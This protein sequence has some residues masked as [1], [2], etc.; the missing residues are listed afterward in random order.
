MT[1]HGHGRLGRLGAIVHR[2]RGRVVL[3]WIAALIAVIALAPLL[4][5]SSEADFQ[6]KGSESARASALL[7]QRFP[8]RSG[9]SVTVVWKASDARSRQVQRRVNGFLQRAER[10]PAVGDAG[11][12][13]VS[14]DGTIATTTLELDR[15]G[16]DVPDATGT[17]LIDLAEQSSGDGLTILLGGNVIRN[18]EGGG[19]PEGVGLLAAAVVLLIAFGSI[20]AAGLPLAVALFG[21]GIS[22]SLIGVLAAV[23]DV[24]DF[25]PA[26]AGLLGIGVGIDYA[27]L[28]LTR[29][30]ATLNGGTDVEGAVVEAVATAGRSVLVAGTTVLISVLGLFLMGVS[31]L[32][33]VALSASLA[34]LVVM[35]A[36]VTLLPALLS[37]A[38]PRVNKLRIPG[39][40]RT[41]ARERPAP[42]A[43]WSRFIQRRPWPAAIVGAAIVLAL[44][45]PVLGLRLGFPD[46][47]NDQ[48]GSMTR[49]AYD[50]V[51]EGF[52]P[53]ANGPLLL[54]AETPRS[55]QPEDLQRLASA[56]RA[57]RDVAF[58]A[59]AQPS[60]DGRAAVVAVVP[61]S[62]PQSDATTQLVERLRGDVVPGALT[63]TGVTVHVGG[64]TAAFVDQSDLVSRR[65][66]LFIAG[67][68]GMSFLLLL[69]AFRSP[70]IAAKA[71]LMNLLSVGAAYGVMALFAGGGWFGSDLLGIDQS[72][73]VAPFIPVMMFAILFGLSMDYEV[74]LLSRVREEYL[75]HGDTA[76]AVAEGLAKTARVITAAAAIIV[77]V[78]LAFVTSGEIFLKLLGIGMATAILVDAT[79]VRM[80]LV[81]ALM[82]LLGRANWWMPRWLDRAVPRLAPEAP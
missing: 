48:A 76:R 71:G 54:V 80:V 16:F 19:S 74:F 53:G 58:V 68:I 13:R 28:V 69:S 70:L 61:R 36:A 30:R 73:P 15:P 62:S 18:A 27:L 24:P 47:G 12:P 5:G 39:L 46:E 32:Q 14:R 75:G 29:F 40:G 17:K 21:L 41:L 20:V 23:V 77:V 25:A 67:V 44:A 50:T 52:G 49:V 22:T 3:G 72:V 37:L 2:R 6:T 66:P 10:L 51:T 11:Q 81:P 64:T 33:G 26:V 35:A 45:A 31:Y 59:P 57:D 38:G 63:G 78:F 4:K 43:R 42:A 60:P 8:G 65:L 56:V 34:V 9:D 82:Q 55:T 1:A 7:E 79:V